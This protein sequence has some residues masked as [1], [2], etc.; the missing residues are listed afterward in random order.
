MGFFSRFKK[1]VVDKVKQKAKDTVT[2]KVKDFVVD[3]V[4][5]IL[6]EIIAE[7]IEKIFKGKGI[8]LSKKPEVYVDAKVKL[9]DSKIRS[10]EINVSAKL[11]YLPSNRGAN[12]PELIRDLRRD[13]NT[14]LVERINKVFKGRGIKLAQRPKIEFDL[15]PR[16]SRKTGLVT[17]A[18]LILYITLAR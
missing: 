2:N 3:E 4:E 16:S 7:E 13:F 9:K 12:N 14:I 6:S 17:G 1:T 5:K 8:R 18:D 11:D 15:K 10:G